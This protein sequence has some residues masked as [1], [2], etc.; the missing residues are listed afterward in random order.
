M[1]FILKDDTLL[2]KEE[3]HN[4]IQWVFANK[5]F[6]IDSN[7]RHT[8]Y[9]HCDLM[10]VDESFTESLSDITLQPIARAINKLIDSYL[11]EYPESNN[12]NRWNVEYVRFKWWKPGDSYSVWHSE[13]T[14]NTPYRVLSFLI[15]LS[16]NDAETQ[17]E[18]YENVE[19]KAGS[20][21]LFP[22]Y[23]THQH[24]GS[25]CKKGL[26]RYILSGYCS[27]V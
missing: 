21:I 20:G 4:I 12:L 5:K 26:D 1:N 8:G 2:T 15:Y 9:E 19:T 17:F 14:K 7:N 22:S 16:D 10:H 11:K 25:P 27:F 18:R 13:H 3:C 6:I 24:R 23:F